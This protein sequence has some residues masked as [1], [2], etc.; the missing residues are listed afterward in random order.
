MVTE[1]PTEQHPVMFHYLFQ[2]HQNGIVLGS[3]ELN[4][5]SGAFKAVQMNALRS[6]EE[7]LRELG[8]QMG[9]KLRPVPE[10][11][12][13]SANTGVPEILITNWMKQTP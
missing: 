8:Q 13:E 12:E 5:P 2:L 4:V 6:L 11:E 1:S 10:K 7:M 9:W 3:L